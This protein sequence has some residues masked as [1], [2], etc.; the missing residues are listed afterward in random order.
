MSAPAWLNAP[1]PAAPEPP[2][3]LLEQLKIGGRLVIPLGYEYRA[4]ELVVMIRESVDEFS[5][6]PVLPVSLPS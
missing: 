3:P 6:R 2:P 1:P 4:Q 5:T